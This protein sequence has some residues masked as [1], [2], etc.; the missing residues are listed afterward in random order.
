MNCIDESEKRL[1]VEIARLYYE[2][3][4]TQE[5]IAQSLGMSR[6]K[7]LR[8]LRR[9]KEEGIVITKIR[10]PFSTCKNLE[11]DLER[12]FALEK[13]IV[14]PNGYLTD[15]FVCQEIARWGVSLFQNIIEDGDIVGVG[16]GTTLHE[17][18]RHLESTDKK[19]VRVVPLGGGTGQ[20]EPDFQVNELCKE[21][22]VKIG[23]KAYVLD[24]PIFVENVEAKSVLFK[25]PRVKKIVDFW[26]RLTVAVVGIGNIP[27]LWESRSPLVAL[28]KE[29][30][31]ILK[32]ELALRECVGDIVQNFFDIDG[33]I[34]PISIREN[35]ISI[36]ME[37]LR[38][39]KKVI[40]LSGGKGKEEAV[41][42]ALRGGFIT[43]LV[44]DESVAKYVLDS[45][46]KSDKFIIHSALKF[47][48]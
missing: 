13:V 9:A 23:G 5:E 4:K 26:K 46:L 45:K 33:N 19:D 18:V 15:N 2:K 8:L 37:Q 16:W 41:L 7:I 30:V 35:I 43:H 31:E 27:R 34:S 42:G 32:K 24:V 25:E 47:E 17:C 38:K 40:A 20:I 14:V 29:A 28:S 39:V 22:A 12:E 1:M 6:F 21:I 44:T 11:Q 48:G 10:D 36:P 3:D